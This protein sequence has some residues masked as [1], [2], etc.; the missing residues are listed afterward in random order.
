MDSLKIANDIEKST[1]NIKEKYLTLK[2][3]L[4]ENEEHLNR[5]FNPITKHLKLITDNFQNPQQ[6]FDSSISEDFEVPQESSTPFKPHTQNMSWSFN[7]PIFKSVMQTPSNFPIFSPA[8][9]QK[10]IQSPLIPI[11]SSSFFNTHDNLTTKMQRYSPVPLNIIKE[12]IAGA[13][14]NS[15]IKKDNVQ[16]PL[17]PIPSSS[18]FTSQLPSNSLNATKEETIKDSSNNS[19]TK[20]TTP[21]SLFLT[22]HNSTKTSSTKQKTFSHNTKEHPTTNWGPFASEYVNKVIND[23]MD[24]YDTIYGV[25]FDGKRLLMG[26]T[27]IKINNDIINVGGHSSFLGTPGLY[28]LVFLKEPGTESV[29]RSDWKTYQKIL[30]IT[31]AHKKSFS[32]TGKVNRLVNNKKYTRVISKLFPSR[33]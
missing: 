3:H 10:N 27:E 28:K 4:A 26:N 12:E 33:K 13:S 22:P 24:G 19:T 5:T 17:L 31:K 8:S 2:R 6:S 30:S 20:N 23:E 14:N 29:E 16:S 7:E 18:F 21:S 1:S 11:P 25:R 9:K 15:T 32:P